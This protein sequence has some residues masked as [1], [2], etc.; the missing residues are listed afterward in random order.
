MKIASYY[1]T[2]ESCKSELDISV[3]IAIYV[4]RYNIMY[5][6][7]IQVFVFLE[8]DECLPAHIAK[9]KAIPCKS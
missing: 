8:L 1:I 6:G 9:I 7:I 4:Y 3:I 2:K 5:K